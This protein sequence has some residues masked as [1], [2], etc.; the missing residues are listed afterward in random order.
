MNEIINQRLKIWIAIKDNKFLGQ[1]L[2]RTSPEGYL[3]ELSTITIIQCRNND[4]GGLFPEYSLTNKI[5]NNFV[6]LKN[7]TQQREN[8][9]EFCQTSHI[10]RKD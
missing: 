7:Q 1:I 3:T 9:F 10:P 2:F 4:N 8:Y 5:L 6:A